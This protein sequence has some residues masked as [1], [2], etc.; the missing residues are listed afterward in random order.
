MRTYSKVVT[1]GINRACDAFS[2][3]VQ[4]SGFNRGSGRK[5]LRNVEG[6]EEAIFILRSGATYGA[7]GSPSVSLQLSLSSIRISDGKTTILAITKHKKS[8]ERRVT[9]TIIAS[10]QKQAAPLIDVCKNW[11]YS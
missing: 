9:A 3:I 4:P 2:E 10:T 7:P 6:F 5:W 8:A 1:E 11:I